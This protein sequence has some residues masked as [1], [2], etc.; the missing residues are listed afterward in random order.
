ME[1][2]KVKVTILGQ[3]YNIKGDTSP[4]YILELT[5]YV[6]KKIEEISGNV[7]SGNSLQIAI[8][9]ALNIADECFQSR[10]IAD[11]IEGVIECK[12]KE[13][14]TLLDEGIIGDTFSGSDLNFY[15]Q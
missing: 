9:A 10:K 8:L 12:T 3:T 11:G 5:D 1:S 15:R 13:L 4:E 2:G 14:I 6:N 7:L